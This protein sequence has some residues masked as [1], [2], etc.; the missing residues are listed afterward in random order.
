MTLVP[1]IRVAGEIKTKPTQ[2]SVAKLREIGI[3]PQILIC[4][5]LR[6]RSARKFARK[7]HDVL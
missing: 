3:M 5:S 2:Q 1:F 7:S 4:R 6:S